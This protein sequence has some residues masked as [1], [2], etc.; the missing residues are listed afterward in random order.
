MSTIDIAADEGGGEASDGRGGVAKMLRFN[1][2]VGELND[3]GVS[4]A[5]TIDIAADEGGGEAANSRGGVPMMLRF[6]DKRV[7]VLCT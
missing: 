7:L 2:P 3:G 1:G 5:L 4:T 6:N